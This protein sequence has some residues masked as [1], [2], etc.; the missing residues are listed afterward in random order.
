MER[1]IFGSN[2][3]Y[4]DDTAKGDHAVSKLRGKAQLHKIMW[5]KNT[6]KL[7]LEGLME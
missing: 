7:L 4:S 2:G 6:Y 3:V 1:R 5:F